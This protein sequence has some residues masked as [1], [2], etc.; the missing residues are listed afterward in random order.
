MY[1]AP[2]DRGKYK[3]GQTVILNDAPKVRLS[4][5]FFIKFRQDCLKMKFL[6]K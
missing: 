5:A 3:R 1:H 6:Y 4:A 2:M